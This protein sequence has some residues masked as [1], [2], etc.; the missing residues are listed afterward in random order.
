MNSIRQPNRKL[1]RKITLILTA[2]G[3]CL[4]PLSLMAQRCDCQDSSQQITAPTANAKPTEP[5]P[6]KSCCAKQVIEKPSS[7]CCAT[8]QITSCQC[9]NCQCRVDGQTP[10]QPPATPPSESQNYNGLQFCHRSIAGTPVSDD[11]EKT[12]CYPINNRQRLTRSAQQTC[13]LLSRFTT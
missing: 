6:A 13:V 1:F 11:Q 12:V 9:Q 4:Q 5:K 7:C 10:S 8:E 3:L 2:L